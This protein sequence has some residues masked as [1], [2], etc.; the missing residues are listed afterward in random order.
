MQRENFNLNW[1]FYKETSLKE[2]QE[3]RLPHDAMIQEEKRKDNPTGA[4]GGYFPGGVYYYEKSFEVPAEA[5]EENWILEFEGIYRNAYI[6]LNNRFVASNHSGYR[7][8][9]VELKDYIK[10]GKTNTIKVKVCNDSIKNSRWY[11]G[12]GIYRPVWLWKGGS[13]RI[14]LDGLR[15]ETPEVEPE[16]SQIRL[17][18]QLTNECRNTTKV[19]LQ[20]KIYEESGKMVHEASVPVSLFPGENPTI[21]QRLYMRDVKLWSTEAPNLYRCEVSI[22]E[23]RQENQESKRKLDIVLDQT[24]CNFGIRHIQI[25]PVKGIRIN[26]ETLLL[27]GS[28]IHHDNGILGAATFYDA[29][30]RRIAISKEAGF[31]A[32]R[33]AHQPASKAMLDACDRLGMLIWEESFDMWNRSKNTHDASEYF[34]EEWKRDVEAI[35]AKDYNHPCVFIYC[36]GNEIE[37]LIEEDG[38][39]YSRMLVDKFRALDST[40]PVTNAINGHPAIGQNGPAILREMGLLK[41]EQIKAMT[42]DADAEDEQVIQAFM[43]AFVT[44]EINDVMT[45]LVG[46]LGRVIEHHSVT[47]KLEEIMSHLDLCGYNYM[48]NRYTMDLEQFP[49]RIIVGS[50]TNPPEIDRLWGYVKKYPG[51]IGDFTWSGWD[52]IGE[53][54]V[55][56][57][58]YEGKQ[59]FQAEY[60]AYLAYCGDMDIIGHRRPLSYFREIVFGLRKK[61]YVSVQDPKYFH[62]LAVSTPWAVPET[63]ESWTWPGQEGNKVRVLV[64]APG[65]EIALFCN[66]KEIGRK[67]VGENHR[68]Q[69][70]FETTYEPGEVLAVA[71]ENRR[72][73]GRF[74]IQTADESLR[75][76]SNLS[77]S[78]LDEAGEKISFISIELVDQNGILHTDCDR[79]VQIQSEDEIQVIGFGS[80]DP[81]SKENFYDRE[82]K[83][84]RGKLLAAIRGKKS[85]TSKIRITCNGCEPIELDVLVKETDL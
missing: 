43:T 70:E 62:S 23:L 17:S 73:I 44:G 41:P 58:N 10:Y 19:R 2:I 32:I 80:A 71:Y 59:Q 35:V 57:T 31:N 53:A 64:Y 82:R 37:E 68:Y 27:R 29:E 14:A 34:A 4:A 55:G 46:N 74:T 9:Y 3:V 25:D 16:V 42:G 20:T 50:E 66:G 1:R 36:I 63:V 11:S 54:G 78:E 40:R 18:V 45:A 22:L 28:C 26:G 48:M 85:G 49:D 65:D 72:E 39:R 5:K 24:A 33:I 47:E 69:A 30:E 67:L 8:F 13:I 21:T 77:R 6:Y 56:L 52:Y 83:T 38:I 61:P 12:S 51:C 76:N 15:V 81:Y 7:G 79:I 84:Y 75:L 60:P